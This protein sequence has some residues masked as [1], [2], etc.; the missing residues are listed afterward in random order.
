MDKII[1]AY[2]QCMERDT[3]WDIL[4]DDPYHLLKSTTLS[5]LSFYNK[6]HTNPYCMRIKGNRC[7]WNRCV[8]LKKLFN[9]RIVAKNGG[10]VTCYCGVT[11]FAVPIV[12]GATHLMTLSATGFTGKLKDRTADILAKRIDMTTENFHRLREESLRGAV[13]P[14]LDRLNGYLR[15]AA[16]LLTGYVTKLPHIESYLK[17]VGVGEQQ[18]AYL[19][20]A[21][22]FIHR[23]LADDIR[24]E[25]VSDACHV[26]LSYLQHLFSAVRGHGIASEI[27]E[28]RLNRAEE[29]LCTTNLSVK[30]IAMTVGYYHTDYFSHLFH[31]HDGK[32]PLAFRRINK[33]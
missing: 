10:A 5:G 8:Y 29:L 32:A 30:T 17:T 3:G 26:S 9:R 11:E 25:D 13:E 31:Q 23:N 28:A 18:K 22:D 24:A 7:L 6:Y 14:E 15:A 12:I 33:T 1:A 20:A 16:A 19:T 4:I 27:R 2:L 21:L